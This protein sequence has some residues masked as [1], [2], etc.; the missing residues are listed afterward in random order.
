ML[1][2]LLVLSFVPCSIDWTLSKFLLTACHGRSPTQQIL[3][4]HNVLQ[5][6]NNAQHET[7]LATRSYVATLTLWWLVPSWKLCQAPLHY[8]SLCLCHLRVALEPMACYKPSNG[9]F[10]LKTRTLLTVIR[11]SH[12]H[13]TPEIATTGIP[14]F[15][16][17]MQHNTFFYCGHPQL[18]K[19]SVASSYQ[20]LVPLFCLQ[21]RFDFFNPCF[22]TISMLVL[23]CWIGM[24]TH[25]TF[26]LWA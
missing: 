17:F 12:H 21:L 26:S 2:S 4:G 7:L 14:I 19:C 22:H 10:F 24:S 5:L 20:V 25:Q 18:A 9:R 11:S 13:Y 23:L 15:I 16:I 8:S 1:A 6:P 3:V